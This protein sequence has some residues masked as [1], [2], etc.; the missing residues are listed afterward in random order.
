MDQYALQ[1]CPQRNAKTSQL[2]AMG[3]FDFKFKRGPEVSTRISRFRQ[4]LEYAKRLPG[5][6]TVQMFNCEITI[7]DFFPKARKEE[8]QVILMN[9]S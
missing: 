8:E 4:I 1:L 3:N 5:V 7:F 6:D 2:Q 9:V